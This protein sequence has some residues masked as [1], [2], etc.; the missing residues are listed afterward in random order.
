MLSYLDISPNV[1]GIPS[2]AQIHLNL[3]RISSNTIDIG[4]HQVYSSNQ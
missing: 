2:V 3:L 4:S 1:P